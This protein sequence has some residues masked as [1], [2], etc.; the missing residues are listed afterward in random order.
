MQGFDFGTCHRLEV[1]K[2]SSRM[3]LRFDDVQLADNMERE[4]VLSMGQS[5]T[6]CTVGATMWATC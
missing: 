5:E 6:T 2:S 4:R 1:K 3:M